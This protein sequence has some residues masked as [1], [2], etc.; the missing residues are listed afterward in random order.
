M[1]EG[2]LDDGEGGDGGGGSVTCNGG[3]WQWGWVG[4][5][6]PVLRCDLSRRGDRGG[7]TI[8]AGLGLAGW[9]E[10]G[11]GLCVE[12]RL[13]RGLE[14]KLGWCICERSVWRVSN[15]G[16]HL[17]VKW[18]R[19]WFYELARIFSVKLNFIFS[20]TLFSSG[21]KHGPRC[22]IFSGNHLHQKQT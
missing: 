13:V 16:K 17:K 19:K 20:L 4:A 5:I 10:L 8:W 15:S 18:E 14:L 11:V 12:L 9:L 2:S 6:S 3:A 22:K 21:A 7:G 1:E